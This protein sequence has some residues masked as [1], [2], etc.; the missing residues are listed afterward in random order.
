VG[1]KAESGSSQR[2]ST[3]ARREDL[4]VDLRLEP[5]LS[6]GLG[7]EDDRSRRVAFCEPGQDVVRRFDPLGRNPRG[8]RHHA[9]PLVGD[10]GARRDPQRGNLALDLSNRR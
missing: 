10:V 3:L 1:R 2:R 5:V 4:D 9:C 8:V 6:L 7:N